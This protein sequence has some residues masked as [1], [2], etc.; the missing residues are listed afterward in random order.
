LRE[1]V[2]TRRKRLSPVRDPITKLKLADVVQ[3][4]LLA[5]IQ[6]ENL[7]P[8]DLLPSERELMRS[9]DVGRPSI[10]EAMQNLKRMGLIE[11][12]HGERPR[13]A[14]P[15]FERM[16]ADMGPTM[17]HLLIN[18][19]TT[20]DHLREARATFEMTMAQA[21]ARRRSPQDIADL[22]AILVVQERAR[23]IPTAFLE[24]DGRFH[25]RIAMVSGN[26]IFTS[27][28]QALFA[29]LAQFHF[30]LVRKPGTEKLTLAEHREILDAI[31]RGDPDGATRSMADHLNRSN[32]LYHQDNIRL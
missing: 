15:S 21:A 23:F 7:K 5:V 4:R 8:G 1:K 29:W 31:E 13:V 9:Y 14:A 12:N 28:S 20:L 19:P 2:E 25:S 18:S 27:L 24:A 30:D 32:K 22:R 26:P 3:D 17:R 6:T 11:I 10:R 16:V